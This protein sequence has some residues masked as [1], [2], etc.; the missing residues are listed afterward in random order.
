MDSLPVTNATDGSIGGGFPS[1]KEDIDELCRRAFEENEMEATG[2][3]SASKV[4]RIRHDVMAA[5][6]FMQERESLAVCMERER[7]NLANTATNG[8]IDYT[9]FEDFIPVGDRGCAAHKPTLVKSVVPKAPPSAK[10][11]STFVK[12]RRTGSS[13]TRNVNASSSSPS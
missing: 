6:S 3:T 11:E 4:A 12:A 8:K 5:R 13:C 7:T 2:R 1:T 9:F 10:P